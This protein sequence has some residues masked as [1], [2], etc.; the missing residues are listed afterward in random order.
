M[1]FPNYDFTGY[2]AREAFAM[3]NKIVYFG[4]SGFDSTIVLEREEESEQLHVVRENEGFDFWR[5]I[6]NTSSC[7]IKRE[8]YAFQ[9]GNFDEVHR[10]NLESRK[11][12]LFY[13]YQ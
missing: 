12:T 9:T 2:E 8:I 6:Y 4:A 1:D 11:W 13:S 3:E 10:Y 7:V 5:G